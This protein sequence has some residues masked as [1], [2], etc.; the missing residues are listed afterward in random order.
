MLV[1]LKLLFYLRIAGWKKTMLL[2]VVILSFIS[3]CG[4]PDYTSANLNN[5]NRP[6][7]EVYNTS[8]SLVFN[9]TG[10]YPAS[11]YPDFI[12][13]NLYIGQDNDPANIVKRILYHQFRDGLPTVN[14]PG[15][16]NSYTTT[17]SIDK[18]TF[19]FTDKANE[20]DLLAAGATKGQ[21]Y[22][23]NINVYEKYY[24]VAEAV[25]VTGRK[26]LQTDP[27]VVIL[28]N[29][30]INQTINYTVGLANVGAFNGL[31]ASTNFFELPNTSG[32]TY[33]AYS[34]GSSG[35]VFGTIPKGDSYQE[36]SVRFKPYNGHLYYFKAESTT[37]N[38][39][40]A[41]Q[42]TATNVNSFT[43][44]YGYERE[45]LTDLDNGISSVN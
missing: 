11:Q 33:F 39:Y 21:L 20:T 12:G 23:R 13:Y 27:A 44:S 41:L 5:L 31:S 42:I 38:E 40:L 25:E 45:I 17:F 28:L 6:Q 8:D 22:E 14:A 16:E 37:L 4:V 9:I 19:R 35:N 18:L 15:S 3:S 29:Y 7:L 26:G 2:T 43:Y 32:Y 1:F 10:Y 30:Q 34:V 24:F 36:E